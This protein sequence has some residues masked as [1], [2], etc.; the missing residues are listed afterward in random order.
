LK[1]KL[2]CPA[3]EF[4][5]YKYTMKERWPIRITESMSSAAIGPRRQ[6]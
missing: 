2:K 3:L 5:V 4:K 1:A 6:G